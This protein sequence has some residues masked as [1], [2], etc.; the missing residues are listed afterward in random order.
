MNFSRIHTYRQP[1]STPQIPI[2][3]GW[4][5]ENEKRQIKVY[6]YIVAVKLTA[7]HSI[8]VKQ[9]VVLRKRAQRFAYFRTPAKRVHDQTV[10]DPFG[11][12]LY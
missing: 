6:G 8:H 11:S 4:F 7:Y 10:C 2:D 12:F 5:F 3:L 9:V 1:I